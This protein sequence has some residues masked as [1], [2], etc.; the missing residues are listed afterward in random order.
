ME[1]A[2]DFKGIVNVDD[3][4][5][6]GNA[7]PEFVSTLEGLYV[8]FAGSDKAIER[9]EVRMAVSRSMRRTSAL[10]GSVQ[11]ICFTVV[12]GTG[13]PGSCRSLPG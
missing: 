12:P 9:G 11:T 6:V 8:A 1:N 13:I 7:E 4:E 10:A 2:A 5:P 3:E